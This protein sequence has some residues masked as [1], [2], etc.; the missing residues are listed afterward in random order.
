MFKN[1]NDRFRSVNQLILTIDNKFIFTLNNMHNINFISL[2]KR[3]LVWTQDAINKQSM[4]HTNC[5]HRCEEFKSFIDYKY[6]H[7]SN[8][9]SWSCVTNKDMKEEK[10]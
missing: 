8:T 7:A 4:F 2:K 10:M 1:E 9:S 5:I 3:I 6:I